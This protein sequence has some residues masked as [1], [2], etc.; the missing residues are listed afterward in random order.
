MSLEGTPQGS[1]FLL[2]LWIEIR[3]KFD[4]S[5]ESLPPSRIFQRSG[6]YPVRS[7]YG[8]NESVK[9]LTGHLKTRT[10]WRNYLNS[11]KVEDFVFTLLMLKGTRFRIRDSKDHELWLMSPSHLVLYQSHRCHLQVRLPRQI[12]FPNLKNKLI[13]ELHGTVEDNA[14]VLKRL[15]KIW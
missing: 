6:L 10:D 8:S 2:Q 14:A 11:L 1:L 7:L 12:P 4:L 9:N 3:L 5:E 13:E 15:S